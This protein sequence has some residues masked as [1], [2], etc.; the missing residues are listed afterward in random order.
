MKRKTLVSSILVVFGFLILPP[1]SEILAAQLSEQYSEV[2]TDISKQPSREQKKVNSTDKKHQTGKPPQ[3]AITICLDKPVN[4]HCEV[5]SP[6]GLEAGLCE[7][8]PD[9]L[10]FACNP[11]RDN[12]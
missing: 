10:Y 1:L 12:Q 6:K 11:K 5:K 2:Q 9:N 8:T 4:S 3:D 7:M